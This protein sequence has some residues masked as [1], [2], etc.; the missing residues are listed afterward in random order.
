MTFNFKM[1]VTTLEEDLNKCNLVF[2]YGTL[3]LG[4]G[5]DRILTRHEAQYK[6]SVRTKE[7][8]AMGS[9]GCPFIFPQRVIDEVGG[10]EEEWYAPVRGDLWEIPNT[11]CFASLDMLEGHPSF[12]TR[13]TIITVNDEGNEQEA[14]AYEQLSDYWLYQ[15]SVVD[16]NE[17]GEYEW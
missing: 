8:Y 17:D 4:R 12:Y 15:S 14:W 7:D 16:F 2:T 11:Q 6:G 3:K 5:N 9:S 10:L 1:D 13:T